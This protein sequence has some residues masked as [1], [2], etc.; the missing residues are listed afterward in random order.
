MGVG[1]P[2]REVAHDV[3]DDVETGK[4]QR[5][6]RGALRAAEERPGQGI[7]FLNRH[8]ARIDFREDAGRGVEGEMVADESRG[9]SGDDDA[10]SQLEIERA[11]EALHGRGRGLRARDEFDQREIPGRIEEV[12]ACPV[13]P[14]AVAPAFGQSGHGQCGRVGGDQRLRP[15]RRIHACEEGTFGCRILDDGLDDPVAAAHRGEVGGEAA[16]CDARPD[17]GRIRRVWLEPLRSCEPLDRGLASH[18]EEQ[19]RQARACRER[20]DLRAHR[21]CAEH[22]HGADGRPG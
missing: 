3:G 8:M 17:V 18:I 2:R 1:E 22:G 7:G 12:R 21:A 10:L 16:G 13:L 15:A 20:R 4:I 11:R 6:E 19:Y 14:E 9:I 5:A